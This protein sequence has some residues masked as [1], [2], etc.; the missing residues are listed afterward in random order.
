MGRPRKNAPGAPAQERIRNAFWNVLE[1]KPFAKM[2]V[3]DI[4]DEAQVNRNTFYYHFDCIETLAQTCVK[5]ALPKEI[6]H[7][8]IN[9]QRDP[10]FI[11]N[12]F[13]SS[14]ETFR[15]LRLAC[16]SQGSGALGAYVREEI[17]AFW[18]NEFGIDETEL[19]E[20]DLVLTAFIT[21]GI[22]TVLGE[23]YARELSTDDL[24]AYLSGPFA[25]TA[26]P[27]AIDALSH[28][29]EASTKAA[30]PSPK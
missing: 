13:E 3:K 26:M 17:C 4:V 11:K 1:R 14:D 25:Q 21:G 22:V 27:A 10:A 9:G 30:T 16:N 20:S 28:A 24:A 23:S 2:T 7:S 5:E 8:F 18:L 6:A 19:D 29:A 12:V 15:R